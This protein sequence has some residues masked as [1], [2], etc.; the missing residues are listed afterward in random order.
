M[1]LLTVREPRAV[2]L[3]RNISYSPLV[4][5]VM[6]GG[7]GMSENLTVPARAKPIGK[8]KPHAAL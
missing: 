2:I 8:T 4:Y 5:Y 7:G 1:P 3:I 6:S